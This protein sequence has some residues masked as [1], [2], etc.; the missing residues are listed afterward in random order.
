MNKGIFKISLGLVAT[1]FTS[2]FCIIVIPPLTENPD[3]NAIL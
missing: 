3:A 1:T 2:L